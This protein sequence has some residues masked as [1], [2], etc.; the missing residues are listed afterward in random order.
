MLISLVAFL[1]GAAIGRARGGRFGAFRKIQLNG[2]GWL[3]AGIAA[4][5]VVSVIGPSQP[6]IWTLGAYVFFAVFGL[7]N[8]QFAGMVVLLI[9]LTM[10]FTAV[11]ANGAVPVSPRALSSVGEVTALG[12]PIIDGVRESNEIA[13]SFALFGDIVPVPLF[14]VVVS[15]GDLIIAVA[16]VDIAMNIALRSRRLE[17]DDDAYTY[18]LEP[19]PTQEIDLR[20]AEPAPVHESDANRIPRARRGRPAHAATRRARVR[21]LHTIYVPAHAATETKPKADRIDLST[22]T[23]DLRSEPAESLVEQVIVL[24]DA[25]QPAGYAAPQATG[26]IDQRPII[27]LTVS[28]T[29]EQLQEFL[30]RRA[31][32]DRELASSQSVTNARPHRPNARSRRRRPNSRVGA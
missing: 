9:G 12:E 28:P 25:S 30:R 19:D 5:L 17:P 14:N 1:T 26:S 6:A 16:L 20:A 7:R 31:Q 22:P 15:L 21:S 4:T 32:A 24:N 2:P 18:T 23:V 27:D 8:L 29:D 3:A 10:N 11:L 13:T